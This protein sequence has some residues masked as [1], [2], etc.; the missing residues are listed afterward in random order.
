MFI[1]FQR[2]CNFDVGLDT[3]IVKNNRSFGM[4]TEEV[5]ADSQQIENNIFSLR[6]IGPEF[7]ERQNSFINIYKSGWS[8]HVY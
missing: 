3:D 6:D 1:E 5:L 2:W 8:R 4:T 7:F